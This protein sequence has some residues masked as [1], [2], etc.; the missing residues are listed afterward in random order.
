MTVW[1]AVAAGVCRAPRD[2]LSV[3][4][5]IF[6]AGVVPVFFPIL[7]YNIFLVEV[8]SQQTVIKISHYND[9]ENNGQMANTGYNHLRVSNA[10]T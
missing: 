3:H 4:R 10:V 2:D 8:I 1:A 7:L 9:S 5:S 6:V